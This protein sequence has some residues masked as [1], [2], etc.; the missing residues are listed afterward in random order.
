MKYI[1]FA[2]TL[3]FS[4]EFVIASEEGRGCI[5]EDKFYTEGSIIKMGNTHKVCR[6]SMYELKKLQKENPENYY[7]PSAFTNLAWRPLVLLN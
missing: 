4:S 1:I 3:L 6:N 2:F 7:S 5:F